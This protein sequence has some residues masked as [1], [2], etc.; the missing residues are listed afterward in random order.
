[1]ATRNLAVLQHDIGRSR[2]ATEDERPDN[3][4]LTPA[5]GSFDDL[6]QQ[7]HR[8]TSFVSPG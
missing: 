1:M 7:V 3:R 8:C 5:A 2:V 6:H 4:D